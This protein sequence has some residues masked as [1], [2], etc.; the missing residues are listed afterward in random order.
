MLRAGM[1]GYARDMNAIVQRAY[2]DPELVLVPAELPLPTPGPGEV[3]VRVVATT[4]NTPDWLCTLGRPLLIRP[5]FGVFGPRA[6]VRGTDFAGE[7]DA[8]GPGVE[9][10]RV[11]DAVFGSTGGFPFARGAPGTFRS[12]TVAPVDRVAHKPAALDWDAA[13]A[14]VMSGVVATTAFG[15]VAPLARGSRVLVVG[16]SGAIGTFAVPL[17]RSMGAHV[18][19]V[20]SAANAAM[21]RGLGAD[22]VIDHRTVDWTTADETW[23]VILDNVMA[24][25]VRSALRRLR[26]GGVLL[27]NSVGPHPWWGPLPWLLAKAAAGDRVRT[28]PHEPTRAHLEAAARTLLDG[29]TRCV[30]DGVWSLPE[31]GRAV[32]RKASHRGRGQV[33]IRVE[34]G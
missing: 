18:T 27:A 32:A 6:P 5:V 25:S 22:E 3:R 4:V 13:S 29:R 31:A 15:Q 9:G 20:C 17:A 7:V 10:F 14:L 21:V 19:A 30:M 2:G 33:G 16:A 12:H 23:D 28:L 11:G 26:P 34:A 8:L 24:A 1:H